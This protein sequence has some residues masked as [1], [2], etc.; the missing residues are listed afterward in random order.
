MKAVA[1]LTIRFE[2]C[3][4]WILGQEDTT[5]IVLKVPRGSDDDGVY[6]M[7]MLRRLSVFMPLFHVLKVTRSTCRRVH[8][9]TTITYTGV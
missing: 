1:R 6:G 7:H 4:K 9:R 2:E 5:A 8:R 3:G